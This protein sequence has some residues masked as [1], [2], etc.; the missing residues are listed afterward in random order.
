MKKKKKNKNSQPQTKNTGSYKKKMGVIACW[1][2][3]S[4]DFSAN[5]FEI[6]IC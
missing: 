2:G 5:I 4:M 3:R 1:D 6:Q